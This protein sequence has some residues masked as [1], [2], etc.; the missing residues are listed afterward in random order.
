LTV[1]LAREVEKKKA[2][3]KAQTAEKS[4]SALVT[5]AKLL[6]KVSFAD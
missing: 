1:L 3:N 5:N 6:K 4:E 2:V